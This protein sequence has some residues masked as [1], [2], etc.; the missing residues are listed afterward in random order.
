MVSLSGVAGGYND[1]SRLNGAIYTGI[2]YQ[3]GVF[4]TRNAASPDEVHSAAVVAATVKNDFA[5]VLVDDV[6]VYD[7]AEGS[8]VR[9]VVKGPVNIKMAAGQ[10]PVRGGSVFIGKANGLGYTTVASNAALQVD[11]TFNREEGDGVWQIE[12]HKLGGI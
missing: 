7:G 9:M 4:V 10:V 2:T 11:A 8:Q 6:Y 1:Q 3:A 5:G 12:L